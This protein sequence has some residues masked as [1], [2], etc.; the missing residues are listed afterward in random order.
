M[1]SPTNVAREL[2]LR[3]HNASYRLAQATR[4]EKDSALTAIAERLQTTTWINR[5]LEANAQDC[6]ATQQRDV[7][8]ALLDRLR[9]DSQR[10]HEICCAVE[11]IT[12]LSDPVGRV[13][14]LV[15]QRSGIRV[16]RM[17]VPLGTILM[18]YE[19]RPNVT[20]DAAALLLKSGNAAILRGGR[21]AANT[22]RALSLLIRESLESV[23]LP[24]D[25]VVY[26]DSPDYEILYSLLQCNDLIDLAVPRGGTNLIREVSRHASVPVIKHYQGICHVYIH[27]SADVQ[28]AQSIVLNAKTQRPGVCNAMECLLVDRAAAQRLLPPIATALARESVEI[29]ACPETYAILREVIDDK[30]LVAAND[31]DWDSEY[32]SLICAMK[33]VAGYAEATEFIGQHGS[34]HTEAILTQDTALA[35]RFMREVDASCVMV[36]ASTRFNDGGELGLGAELGIATTKL[37]AYGPMGIEDLCTRKYVVFGNGNIRS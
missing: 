11:E 10:I 33:V 28:Q 36:N 4:M 19:S 12:K 7:S 22:N 1:T 16:G 34:R 13:S 14:E 3:A 21:D 23:D 15:Q 30:Q 31:S 2:A 20:V 35:E 25:C 27:E 18:V 24:G 5:I 17:T 32:L 8:A 6:Q 9:L 26:V 37:H 29:R